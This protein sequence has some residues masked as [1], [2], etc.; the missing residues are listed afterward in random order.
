MNI[1]PI[2]VHFPIAFLSLYVLCEVISVKRLR[3]WSSWL[4]LKA[5]LVVLGVITAVI[6]SQTGELAA[7][8]VNVP[9]N[10]LRVHDQW[11]NLTTVIFGVIAFL[12]IAVIA[13]TTIVRTWIE[14]FKLIMIWDKAVWLSHEL[15]KMRVV[16]TVLALSGVVAITVTG[17]LGGAMVYGP[18]VDPIVRLIYNLLI[19]N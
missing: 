13:D 17:G 6:T 19:S 15:L 4:H 9:R 5:L 12:Y 18:D 7:S 8:I 11:A 14:K 16:M 10:V 1:H 2:L 3:D